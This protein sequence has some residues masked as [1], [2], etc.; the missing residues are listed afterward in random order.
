[1]GKKWER[2]GAG[3]E[4]NGG[5]GM[6]EERSGRGRDGVKGVG[7]EGRVGREWER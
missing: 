4:E 3:E 2:K 7:E 6:G 1:M 5:M